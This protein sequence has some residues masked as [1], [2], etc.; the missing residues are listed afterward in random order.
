[1]IFSFDSPPQDT[2]ELRRI[3]ALPRRQ[4]T[5][6]DRARFVEALSAT[7]RKPG[8]TMTLWPVQA[9]ALFEIAS[10]D[11]AYL[12]I[13]VSGGKT[14]ISLLAPTVLGASRPLLIVPAKL[15]E[16]TRRDWRRLAAHW[17][18][19]EF[20]RIQSYEILCR[21]SAAQ[22]IERFRPDA[23]ILDEAHKAKS[24]KA[25]VTKRIGRYLEAHPE[26][27]VVAMTGTITKRSILDYAH[28]LRWSLGPLRAPVPNDWETLQSWAGVLDE[29][30]GLWEVEGR[31]PGALTALCASGETVREGFRRRLRE[32]PGVV[33]TA[34]PPVDVPI[35]IDR[36]DAPSPPAE[37]REAL[38][39]LR[40]TWSTPDGQEFSD[41]PSLW[42]HARELAL[43]FCYV[44]HP[45]PPRAWL[46][47]RREWAR[48]C[49]EILAV[50][51]AVLDTELQVIQAVDRGEYAYARGALAA[52]RAIRE[53]YEP[54]TVPIWISHYLT[55]W[56]SAYLAEAPPTLVWTAHRAFALDLEKRSGVPYFG[57]EAR[58]HAG[59]SIIDHS[60]KESA[61]CS[62]AS[63]GEGFNLQTWSRN[64]FAP[65]PTN[66]AQLEQVLGRTH[67]E[68]QLADTIDVGVV[69]ASE[70]HERALLQ[71]IRDARYTLATTGEEQKILSADWGID[72]EALEAK[73]T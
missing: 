4:H 6:A 64:L 8:G 3:L 49:R 68:G 28:L 42:R 23:I 21:A 26:T 34:T 70:E 61:V 5:D 20:L 52:W 18:I 13:R 66:G 32:T 39:D 24:P 10:C 31:N 56:I 2:G 38:D 55:E 48:E 33:T 22:D 63:V 15:V 16:K 25:A 65:W 54:T 44:W 12:P 59:K 73:F 72:L 19:P 27:R 41:A 58:T 35:V 14:L 71:T 30:P 67:R 40:R 60:P 11:G 50:R 62:L 37:V 29:R 69:L 1:M 57:R 45:T 46:E 36:A 47:A 43:G 9:T 17:K 53:T 51:G 7:L